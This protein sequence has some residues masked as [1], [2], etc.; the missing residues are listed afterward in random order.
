MHTLLEYIIET[1]EASYVVA[2]V[3]LVGFIPFWSF[4]TAREK[5]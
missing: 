3:L 1:K 4:L 2:V 5:K